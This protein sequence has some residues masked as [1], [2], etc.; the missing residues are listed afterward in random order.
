MRPLKYLLAYSLPVTVAVSFSAQGWLCYLP[1]LYGFGFIPLVDQWV[2]PSRKNLSAA[3]I[4]SAKENRWYDVIIYLAL[5]VQLM[6]LGW[7]L[8]VVQQPMPTAD[9]VGKITAMG[10]MCGV[11]GINV[12]HELGHRTRRYERGMAKVLLAT[13]LYMHFYI[14]HNKGHHRNVG[15]SGDGATARRNEGLYVFWMRTLVQSF[16]SA[17]EITTK[18]LRRKKQ[19]VV[20]VHNE[21][22]MML[23]LQIG[24]CAGVFWLFSMHVLMC[25][26]GAALM[27]I[28]LLETVNYIEHYGL[29]RVKVSEF[30]YEDVEPEHSWNSDH[31]LGRLVLFELTRHSDHHWEPSKHYQALSSMQ[32]ALQLPAG[33]PAMMLLSLFPPIWFK[34][35]NPRLPK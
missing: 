7:F 3:E 28:L 22:L 4:S 18:E 24:L 15:T 1:L 23:L 33:Y 10:M 13:S 20:S 11:L 2:G 32:G 27:G 19:P 34:L 30:R 21:M 29:Y 14:E 6:M 26:L 16:R 31:A 5:P 9:L 17:W 12:A 35:M 25:F 8:V